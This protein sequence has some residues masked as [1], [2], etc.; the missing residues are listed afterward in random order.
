MKTIPSRKDLY[1][2]NNFQFSDFLDIFSRLVRSK[3]NSKNITVL[4]GWNKK[5]ISKKNS[6]IE[7]L[8][9]TCFTTHF[10]KYFQNTLFL[11]HTSVFLHFLPYM[12]IFQSSVS[13]FGTLHFK[14]SW[15]MAKNEENSWWSCLQPILP[16]YCGYPFRHLFLHTFYLVLFS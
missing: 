4:I 13:A 1:I 8:F 2:P 9:I 3:T 10:T 11:L 12:R 14:K 6:W 7:V 5:T 16:W 15:N